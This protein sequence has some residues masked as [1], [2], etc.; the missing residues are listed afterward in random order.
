MDLKKKARLDRFG[1]GEG[2]QAED[3][4]ALASKLAARAERFALTKSDSQTLTAKAGAGK[5]APAKVEPAKGPAKP[6]SVQE[7]NAA[8]IDKAA[9]LVKPAANPEEEAKRQVIN[10]EGPV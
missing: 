5:E 7:R 6:A 4:G 1:S 10:L 3:S 2:K 8:A 9:A